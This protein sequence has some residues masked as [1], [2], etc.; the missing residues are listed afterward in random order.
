MDMKP[1][2]NCK[3]A[4]CF[5]GQS[6]TYKYCS[7]SINNFFRTKR[8][9]QYFFFG[10]TWDTNDYSIRKDDKVVREHERIEDTIFL[11]NDIAH[12][13]KFEDFVLE[14]E[15]Y[16]PYPWASMF[17]SKM[18]SN[19]LK[20]KYEVENNMMF[21]LVINCRFDVCFEEG[22]FFEDYFLRTIEEKTLYSYLGHMNYEFFMPTIDDVIY[23]GSSLTMDLVDSIY[24]SLCTGGFLKL[25]GHNEF[26]PAFTHVGP[27]VLMT[28]WIYIK[29]IL[30]YHTPIPY[31]VYRKMVEGL[32]YKTDLEEIKQIG[33]SIYR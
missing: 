1:F 4:V 6:R 31:V 7:E 30:P 2:E 16:R 8:N 3:V 21:D 9:N 15:I 25:M 27:G 17:Y 23:F 14:K 20:Q 28:K 18:R 33:L 13:F 32:N 24:N 22:K 26:N 29:N 19:F 12:H 11:K 10:H 5:N